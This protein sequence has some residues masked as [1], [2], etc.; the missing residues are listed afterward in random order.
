MTFKRSLS[1]SP[2]EPLL[3]QLTSV[4]YVRSYRKRRVPSEVIFNEWSI[5]GPSGTLIRTIPGET[6]SENGEIL[7]E[8]RNPIFGHRYEIKW[9]KQ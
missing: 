7:W 5:L 2:L 1:H 8:I 9:P 4:L 3:N 6:N